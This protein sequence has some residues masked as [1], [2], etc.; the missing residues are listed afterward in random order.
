MFKGLF[1]EIINFVLNFVGY[2]SHVQP[3][4]IHF[5][6]GINVCLAKI[7]LYHIVGCIISSLQKKTLF[8]KNKNN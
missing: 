8:I 7:I 3:T 1:I 6:F 4:L 5:F 2:R